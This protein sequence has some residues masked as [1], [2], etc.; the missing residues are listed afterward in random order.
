VSSKTADKS[1]ARRAL[2]EKRIKQQKRQDALRKLR[3]PLI[4]LVVIAVVV[5]VF[6]AVN[7]SRS[8]SATALPAGVPTV[9]AGIPEGAATG[10]PHLDIYEDF[11]CPIC[12]QVE[13]AQNTGLEQMVDAGKLTISYHLMTFVSQNFGSDYSAR[14]AAAAGCAQDQGKYRAYHDALF[15]H[16]PPEP[17]GSGAYQPPSNADLIGFA[18]PAGLDQA[19]FGTCV[20]KGTYLKFATKANDAG[21]SVMLKKTGQVATPMILLN[22][23]VTR[24]YSGTPEAFQAAITAAGPAK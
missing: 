12:K 13:A 15:A 14:A 19:A 6:V 17:T 23:N 24:D 22:G 20:N 3:A 2:R 21:Q 10:V 8:N 9:A 1:D 5:G 4:V 7:T 16:Q 18:G 11:A